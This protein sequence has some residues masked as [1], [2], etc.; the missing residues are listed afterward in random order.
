M[1]TEATVGIL[2]QGKQVIVG[3]LA[4]I[5]SEVTLITYC[6]NNVNHYWFTISDHIIASVTV[7]TIVTL[8]TSAVFVIR[9]E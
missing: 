8:G 2:L 1:G 4:M 7:N 5:R 6:C 9:F 3:T